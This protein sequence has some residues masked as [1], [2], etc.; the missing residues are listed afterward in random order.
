[1]FEAKPIVNRG[2][3]IVWTARE[4]AKIARRDNVEM[5]VVDLRAN[6][7]VNQSF[8]ST[9]SNNFNLRDFMAADSERIIVKTTSEIADIRKTLDKGES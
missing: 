4:I 6:W 9:F 7:A 2:K 5:I 8:L 1:M 3:L